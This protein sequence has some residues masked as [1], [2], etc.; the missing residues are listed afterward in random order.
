ML[1]AIFKLNVNGV[2][3][4]IADDGNVPYYCFERLYIQR[5]GFSEG[6]LNINDES[7]CNQKDEDVHEEVML[8]KNFSLKKFLEIFHNNENVE[9]KLLEVDSN[10]ERIMTICHGKKECSHSI[11]SYTM[12]RTQA[13][14]KLLM[15]SF[16][17][18]IKHL[19]SQ[20]F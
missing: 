3:E 1:E 12:R 7:C 11:L 6:E 16:H 9:Y 20:C 15:I 18:E 13:L 19:N 4:E 8:A 5:K 14:F 10:L 2:I 17:K